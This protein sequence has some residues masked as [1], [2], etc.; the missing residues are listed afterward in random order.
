MKLT[1]EELAAMPPKSVR[2]ADEVKLYQDNDFLTAYGLHTD[3]RIAETGYKAAIGGGENWDAHGEFQRDFLISQ[4]LK[5]EHALLDIG[6]GTGRLARKVVPYLDPRRYV[7]LDISYEAINNCF[8]LAANEGWGAK[9]PVF[10]L[11][12]AW[13]A[14]GTFDFVWAFSVF[15]HL[16]YSETVELM[17]RA[18]CVMHKNSKFLFSYVPETVTFRSGLKQFRKTEAQYVWATEEAGLT[19]EDVPG[20]VKKTL[21]AEPRWAGHQ[22]MALARLA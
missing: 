9:E 22:R 19:F 6:C 2:Y 7:G 15:I 18:A 4:G 12:A 11:D 21:G 5:P 16:P 8:F 1:D 3:K 10:L 13:T 20:W 17:K 14:Q